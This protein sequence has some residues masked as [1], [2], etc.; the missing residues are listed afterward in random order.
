MAELTARVEEWVDSVA[1]RPVGL[2]LRRYEPAQQ[3]VARVE[4]A[5]P[6]RR[7]ATVRAG[8]DIRGDGST[9]AYLG[10]VSKRLLDPAQSDDLLA[11]IRHAYPNV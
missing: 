2:K 9:E 8:V 5:G 7:F 1:A 10:R 4:L 3:V 6:Q 11:A